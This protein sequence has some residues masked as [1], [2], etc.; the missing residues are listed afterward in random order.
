[1]RTPSPSLLV[2]MG[3]VLTSP[4]L[5][6]CSEGKSILFFVKHVFM[7]LIAVAERGPAHPPVLALVTKSLPTGPRAGLRPGPAQTP[8]KRR[9]LEEG[10]IDH[11]QAAQHLYAHPSR[12]MQYP[13]AG[14][15]PLR[16]ASS[17]SEAQL[18]GRLAAVQAEIHRLSS[19][20]KELFWQ[21]QSLRQRESCSSSDIPQVY[22]CFYN[23]FAN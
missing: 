6:L 23:P 9:Q 17:L 1:M 16:P 18:R 12:P 20:Q 21:L 2:V 14:L 19:A 10:E 11:S 22:S 8:C 7:S 5:L 13:A 15:A 3:L 4:Y